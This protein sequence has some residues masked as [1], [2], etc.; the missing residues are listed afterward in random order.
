MDKYSHATYA[1]ASTTAIFSGLSLYEW[2][3]VLGAFASISLGILTYR[4]NRREQMKRTLI[5]KNILENLE[6]EPTSKS[7]KIVSELIK[8]SPKDL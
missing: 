4:L 5:L 7:A 3:F 8:Q 2:S 6:L 1:C